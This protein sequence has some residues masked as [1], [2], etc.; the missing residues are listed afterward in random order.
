MQ[1]K[2]LVCFL[3][4]V[5][6]GIDTWHPHLLYFLIKSCIWIAFLQQLNQL[7]MK[8]CNKKTMRNRYAKLQCL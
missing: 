2:F 4:N 6:D 1:P 8:A 3:C 7:S 5:N